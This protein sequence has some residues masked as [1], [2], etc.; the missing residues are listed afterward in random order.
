MN[1]T[2]LFAGL[3]AAILVA[4]FVYAQGTISPNLASKIRPQGDPN[5]VEERVTLLESTV[6]AQAASITNLQNQL[7]QLRDQQSAAIK[8]A[9]TSATQAFST[10]SAAQAGVVTANQSIAAL[11]QKSKSWDAVAAAFPNHT[12]SYKMTTF[13]VTAGQITQ[14]KIGVDTATSPPN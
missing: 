10:A 14:A 2:I 12:H 3:G 5:S 8:A 13:G 7:L 6:K 1:R 4:P 9:Q 11:N